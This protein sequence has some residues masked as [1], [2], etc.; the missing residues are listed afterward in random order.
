MATD[1]RQHKCSTDFRVITNGVRD[2]FKYV[3]TPKPDE[4]K[5][6]IVIA[7]TGRL[8]REK[9]Q[10]DII[11][12]VAKSKY[13]DRI[14]LIIAGAI[15]ILIPNKDLNKLSDFIYVKKSELSYRNLINTTR[16]NLRKRIQSQNQSQKRT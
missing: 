4:Y 9:R 3:N 16:K 2:K 8:A 11:K 5:D 6:K 10:W 15:Y 12:A 1:L 14:K 7:A 13:K